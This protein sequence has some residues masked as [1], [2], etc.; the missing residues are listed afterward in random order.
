MNL[1][2]E[3]GENE[4]FRWEIQ[5]SSSWAIV[6]VKSPARY[7]RIVGPNTEGIPEKVN[8][9]NYFGEKMRFKIHFVE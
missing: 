8:V 3:V 6:S 1:K 5:D 2:Y 9:Q 7:L 4:K